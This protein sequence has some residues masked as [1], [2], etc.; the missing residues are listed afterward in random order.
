MVDGDTVRRTDGIHAAVAFTDRVFFLVFAVEVELQVVQNFVSL[1]GQTILLN[2][3]HNGQFH[4]SQCSRQSQHYARFA[5]FEFF[6]GISMTH[7]AQ[8]HTVNTD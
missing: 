2:Q 5:V 8:E 6:L 1:F 7:Y 4:R 3:R